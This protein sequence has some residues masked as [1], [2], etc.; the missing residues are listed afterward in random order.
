MAEPGITDRAVPFHVMPAKAGIRLF[1]MPDPRLRGGDSEGFPLNNSGLRY[2]LN[3]EI[4]MLLA[5]TRRTPPGVFDRRSSGHGFFRD[6]INDRKAERLKDRPADFF[7]RPSERVQNP[8]RIAQSLRHHNPGIRLPE[9]YRGGLGGKKIT[10]SP[11]VRVPNLQQGL[12]ILVHAVG[13]MSIRLVP[14]T[15]SDCRMQSKFCR[16]L[17]IVIPN[18]NRTFL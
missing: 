14:F 7:P 13:R 1:F 5:S 11:G 9:R 16:T 8:W 6:G 10:Q 2:T 12:S 3:Q 18:K 4:P 15:S 17:T